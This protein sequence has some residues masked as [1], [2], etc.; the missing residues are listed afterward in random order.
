MNAYDAPLVQQGLAH[1]Y[2]WAGEHDRALE[3]LEQL[4]KSPG[5]LN[6]GQLLHDPA[7]E[8]LR[9]K[10]RFQALTASLA[11]GAE[12]PAS[13]PAREEVRDEKSIAVLPFE[14]L[15]VEPQNAFL[16][17]GVQDAILTDLGK[18]GRSEGAEPRQRRSNIPT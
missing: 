4:V 16:A 9:G 8:P 3:I 2:A 18:G 14:N 10:P 15:S 6:Y 11:P 5:Y 13:S 12:L 7:W 17:V 1:V